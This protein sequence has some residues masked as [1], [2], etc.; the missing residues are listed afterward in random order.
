MG[1]THKQKIEKVR[2]IFRE[3]VKSHAPD[4]QY[5]EDVVRESEETNTPYATAGNFIVSL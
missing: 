4:E 2:K 3:Y 5:L 1:K